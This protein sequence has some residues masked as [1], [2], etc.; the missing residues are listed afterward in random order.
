MCE[1][2]SNPLARVTLA[3]GLPYLLV[4]RALTRVH[5]VT[6]YTKMSRHLLVWI[7]TRK[8]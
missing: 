7:L 1:C 6:N 5:C 4:N 2:Q 3:L 8:V